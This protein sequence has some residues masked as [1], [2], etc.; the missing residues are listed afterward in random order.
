MTGGPRYNGGVQLSLQVLPGRF[1][2]ARLAPDEPV[3]AWA[4]EGTLCSVT[5]TPTELSVVCDETVVPPG[6]VHEPDWACLQLQG[7]F[8]F[9]LT[10][11]LLSVL[12]PLADAQVGIFAVSTFDTDAV[13]V[14]ADKLA[15]AVDALHAAGH[16][17]TR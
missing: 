9:G 10:G 17:V 7:P 11:I 3:P 1:A 15:T 5:R 12:A 2:I 8:E 13:L 16:T 14:K 4:F 6:V